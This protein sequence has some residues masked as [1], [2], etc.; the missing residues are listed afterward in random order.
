MQTTR[1][2][3]REQWNAFLADF[4]ESHRDAEV[5]VEVAGGDLGDQRLGTARALMGMELEPKGS[6]KGEIDLSLQ[7]KGDAGALMDH[8]IQH[9]EHLY[10][11]EGTDDGVDCL[12]IED[13]AHRKTLIFVKGA[14]A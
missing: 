14:Q 8:R 7:L 12:S 4:S 5:R 6:G 3:P 9:P 10:L 1:E 2:I 13:R 11:L